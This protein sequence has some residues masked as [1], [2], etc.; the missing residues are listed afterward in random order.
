LSFRAKKLFAAASEMPTTKGAGLAVRDV[1]SVSASRREKC[2]AIDL[3][4][5]AR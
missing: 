5:N 2:A 1:T 4:G 3:P